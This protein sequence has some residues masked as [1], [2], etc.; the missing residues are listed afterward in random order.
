LVT[1]AEH[2]GQTRAETAVSSLN[3]RLNLAVAW[4]NKKNRELEYRKT[5]QAAALKPGDL[6]AKDVYYEDEAEFQ[7]SW[8][9]EP[10]LTGDDLKADLEIGTLAD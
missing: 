7:A 3:L 9:L 8:D 4:G 1:Q 10:D 6:G 5:G 2:L